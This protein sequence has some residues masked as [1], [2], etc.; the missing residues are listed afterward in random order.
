MGGGF[1]LAEVVLHKKS[2]LLFAFY[3]IF[4]QILQNLR[5]PLSSVPLHR[6]EKCAAYLF[7]PPMVLALAMRVWSTRYYINVPFSTRLPTLF[8][9]IAAIVAFVYSFSPQKASAPHPM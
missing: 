9:F 7:T 6:G 4:T 3:H 5:N 8:F 1:L 2:V